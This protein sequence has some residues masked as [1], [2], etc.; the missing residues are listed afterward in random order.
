MD[1]RYQA[2]QRI[3]EIIDSD[4]EKNSS[5]IDDFA[6]MFI[7]IMRTKKMLKLLKK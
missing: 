6:T 2:D 4:I 7:S 1:I 3:F 5:I